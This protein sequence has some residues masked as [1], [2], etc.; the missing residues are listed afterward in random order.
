[1]CHTAIDC[2]EITVLFWKCSNYESAAIIREQM[3]ISLL[4]YLLLT[5]GCLD[6][7]VESASFAK[8]VV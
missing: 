1:M 7:A 6:H 2:M 8:L 5:S 4:Q 3:I